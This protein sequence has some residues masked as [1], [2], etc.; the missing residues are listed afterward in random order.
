[1]NLAEKN[2][3]PAGGGRRL[4]SADGQKPLILVVDDVPTNVALLAEM[5]RSEGAE[6][7]LAESGPLALQLAR[8]VPYPDIVLL[9]IMMPEMDGH[10]V[11]AELR[12]NPETRDIPVIFITALDD[13]Q[14]E[15]RGLQEGAADYLFKPIKFPILIAR[16]HAQLELHRTRRLLDNQKNWL[17]QEVARRSSEN[18][19]LE[20]RL[21]LAFESTG[22]GIWEH[23]HATGRNQWNDSLCRLLGYAEG[24][25]SI[26]ECLALI[27][28]EDIAAAHNLGM[29][30]ESRRDGI[31]VAEFRMHHGDGRWLWVEVRSRAIRRN[32]AGE[33]SLVIGTMLDISARKAAEAERQLASVVFTGINDGICITDADQVILMTNEAFAQFTGYGQ[34]EL[35]GRTPGLLKSGVHGPAFYADIWEKLGRYNNWQGEITNR[36]KDGS[37]VSA[38]LSISCVR[39][40]GG[41]VTH[42]VGVFSDLSERKAAAERIQYLASYDTLTE[43]PNRNLFADRLEQSLIS[44]RRF[45]RGTAVI[46]LDI[47]RLRLINDTFGPPAGDDVLV[48]VARRLR[49]QVREG[50]T[51]GRRGGNE[52]GFIM[53]SLGQERDALALAQRML[54]AIAVPFQFAGQ[55]M[56][57]TASIGISVSP[58]NGESGEALLKCADAALLRAKKAGRNTFRFY[59]SEMDAD[60]ARRLAL[61]GG[62]REALKNGEMSV[63]YQPQISLDSGHMVGMEALLRW[64]SPQFGHISPAEFIPIAEETGLIITIGEWVLRTA[65]QQ[66]KAWLDLGLMPLRVAVNL[67]TRQFRQANLLTVVADALVESGLPAGALELEIT[68]SAFIDDLDDAVLLCR[69]LKAMGVK[70]SLDDFGTGYSSLAYIS[71]FPFD[72]L[73]IDQGFVR[74]IIENPVNAAIATAAIVM[75]RSLNLSVLAEGVETEAQASFLRARR[76]D[77]MQGF[78]FSRAL[79]AEEFAPLLLGNK[80][81]PIAAMPR[82]AMQTLLLVDDEPNILNSLSRLLRREGYTILTASSPLEAFE[83]LAKNAV[84]VV[85]SDQRMPDMSGTEFLSKVR[86]LYPDTVRLVLTGYTDLDSVTGAINHGAIYKFLTKPWDD[87]Q[88][89]EQIREAFRVSKS[90]AQFAPGVGS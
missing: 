70:L 69:K 50:D 41:T 20:S 71:R 55:S 86:Q 1:M 39:D 18:A 22:F 62:L 2:R 15:E 83:L 44:A 79:P 64:H 52:F 37:L 21:K 14:D 32:A 25:A 54:E 35:L 10:A 65:C 13:Q 9:D 8:T 58:K 47:D 27:H 23:D 63:H 38:W 74:D 51:V 57:I 80:R 36:R 77:S 46:L 3:P 88:L 29:L 89:R 75:A 42:Y 78:L 11:L 31:E 82:E 28:P 4:V 81:L 34:E 43:L 17:E 6:V 85:I 7:R 26:A 56:V 76:C 61:E 53:A 72:K 87:D 12:K 60:A 66:T 45:E 48:E 33:P 90:A 5:V 73:K 59:S 40:S 67:S 84:Q 19:L 30:P 68:E 24:P 49:L 16:V